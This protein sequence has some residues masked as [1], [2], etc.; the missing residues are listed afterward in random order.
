MR[1]GTLLY[2]D[3]TAARERCLNYVKHGIQFGVELN[4]RLLKDVCVIHTNAVI[5]PGEGMTPIRQRAT[6]A[7]DACQYVV[8]L[9]KA[10]LSFQCNPERMGDRVEYLFLVAVRADGRTGA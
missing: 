1:P 3:M 4:P 6:N 9:F 8:N 5:D 10:E 7:D 2:D